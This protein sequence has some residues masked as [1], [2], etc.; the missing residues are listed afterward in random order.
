MLSALGVCEVRAIVLVDGE[1]ESAFE[2]SDVVLEEV[3]VF[4]KV[5]SLEGEFAETF[6]SVCVSC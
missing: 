6:S 2:G 1:T 3:G 4:I 5:D